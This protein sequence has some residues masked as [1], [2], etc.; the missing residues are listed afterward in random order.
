MPLQRK[1]R[2]I[3]FDYNGV[4]ADDETPHFLTFQQALQEDGLALTKEDYYGAY[5][6]M[7]ERNCATALVE[8]VIGTQ[9]PAR[10]QRILDRKAALFRD[11]T[12]TYKPQLFPGVVEFVKPAGRR[13]RLA[14]ASGGRMEQIEFALRDTPIEKDFAVIASSED[15][16]IGKPDPAIYQVTLDRINRLQPRPRP[17][18]GP[19]ECL[20]IEDSLAGIHSAKAAGMQVIGLATTYQATQL[21]EAHLVIP[22]L[23]GLSMDRLEKLFGQGVH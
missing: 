7:D 18:I 10:I 5:L 4:I 14:I 20:V 3:I 17:P 21:S 23:E 16:V 2:A 15:T 1:I 19:E 22:S 11:Y 6:G 12:A 9:D 8:S 13:Y